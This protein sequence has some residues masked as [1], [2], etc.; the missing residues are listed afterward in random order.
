MPLPAIDIDEVPMLGTAVG[1]FGSFAGES[2]INNPGV[3]EVTVT[4][5]TII[6]D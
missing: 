2:A 5:V 3:F 1:L 6:Y 4:V